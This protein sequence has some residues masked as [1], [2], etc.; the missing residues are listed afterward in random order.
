MH[1]FELLFK[2]FVQGV[3]FRYHVY[4]CA[5]RHQ[6]T[7]HVEN[8]PDGQVKAIVQSATPSIDAFIDDLFKTP[9]NL[10]KIEK[11]TIEELPIHDKFTTFSIRY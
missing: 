10:I 4:Q 6:L 9:Y 11:L 3:G 8:L 5:T 2:G 1:T 7:G